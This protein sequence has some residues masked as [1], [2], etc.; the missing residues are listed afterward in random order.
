[1][2]RPFPHPGRREDPWLLAAVATGGALG[3]LLRFGVGAGLLHHSA[4]GFPWGTLSANVLGSFLLGFLARGLE[5]REAGPRLRA[6]ASVGL[7][8]GFTTFSTFDLESRI[9]LAEGRTAAAVSYSLG[10][11]AVCVASIL[12]GAWLA[13]RGR[14]GLSPEGG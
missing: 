9:L 10:S 12:A 11:V 4:A 14:V 8:G 5:L 3:A 1:M 7:C 13:G 6:F 2:S